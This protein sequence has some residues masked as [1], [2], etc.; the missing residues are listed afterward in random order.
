MYSLF[1][2]KSTER[3]YFRPLTSSFF[4]CE[5]SENGEQECENSLKYFAFFRLFRGFRIEKDR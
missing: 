1:G 2:I 5:K 3:G 4:Q